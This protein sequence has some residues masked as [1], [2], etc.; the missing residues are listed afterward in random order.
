MPQVT[1]PDGSVVDMP[2]VITPELATRL[3]ALQA[4]QST[5]PQA[6][7]TNQDAGVAATPTKP[8]AP[9]GYSDAG[10][11]HPSNEQIAAGSQAAA[12]SPGGLN[13]LT[14]P[15]AEAAKPEAMAGIKNNLLLAHSNF[16]Q[17]M[18]G[19]W[20]HGLSALH[21]MGLVSD[22]TYNK[23]SAR[24]K[25]IEAERRQME[26]GVGHPVINQAVANPMNLL[27]GA[28][29][30]ATLGKQLMT[31]VGIGAAYAG[32][33]PNATWL[34]T[35]VGGAFGLAS[36]PAEKAVSWMGSKAVAALAE[37]FPTLAEKFG[38]GA[39]INP[40]YAGAP[41]LM[42]E[43]HQRGIKSATW[44]DATGDQTM[45]A[46]QNSMAM[47]NREMM[48]NRRM[49]NQ[50]SLAHVQGVVDDLK[51]TA[52]KEGWGNLDAIEAAAA[53][54]GKRANQATALLT[55]IKNSGEDWQTIVKHS[56]NV[57]LFLDKLTAD[58]KF[59]LAE[60]AANPLGNLPGDHL[61]AQLQSSIK[62][63]GSNSA[64]MGE[65]GH[66]FLQK[67]Q[68]GVEGKPGTPTVGGSGSMG[69]VPEAPG[70]PDLIPG[71][72]GPSMVGSANQQPNLGTPSQAQ[73]SLDGLGFSSPA[74]TGPVSF[75]ARG[76]VS[77]PAPPAPNFPTPG[78]PEIP[79]TQDMTFGGLRRLRTSLLDRVSAAEKGTVVAGQKGLTATEISAYRDTVTAIEK[80]LADFAKK[81]P[82]VGKLYDDASAF[83][84]DK[85]V[86]F[87]DDAFGKALAD[88]D[89]TAA[90]KLF[91]TKDP[92]EQQRFFNILP[93]KGQKAVRWGLMEDALNAGE[94]TQGGSMGRTFNAGKVADVLDQYHNRGTMKVA[95]PGGEDSRISLGMAKIMRTVAGADVARGTPPMQTQ[96]RE[97]VQPTVMGVASKAYD[98]MNKENALKLMTDPQG[99]V[100]LQSAAHLSPKSKE[101]VNL[102]T[103]QIPKVLG[104]GATRTLGERA[105][106]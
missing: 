98:W 41:E 76:G 5:P 58:A 74:P 1:M 51:Q 53:G 72:H 59:D 6:G 85:V 64:E 97:L 42:D 63:L 68:K 87:K 2:D 35:G 82:E 32:L 61:R 103:N 9:T 96:L 94:V 12:H 77:A 71:A 90:A 39:K 62:R 17:P 30:E 31:R 34:S 73:P 50:E 67:I 24:D 86:P 55:A 75:T 45:Q 29:A 84:K 99:R 47:N 91:K 7:T 21:S 46:Q 105:D 56:G 25:G 33:D 43:L 11:A 52:L 48:R 15:E 13:A 69:L 14:T 65:T 44:A 49:V 80:D 106:R 27:G 92:A 4:K 20:S 70:A 10:A 38:L 3:R 19:I 89:A 40:E 37:K 78:T 23:E 8:P 18:R 88:T 16:Q 28:G 54:A 81:N 66:N 57:S 93:S 104:I 26:Q 60:A 22:E 100:L 36:L 83:Y 79:A 101:Y 102:V 95:F